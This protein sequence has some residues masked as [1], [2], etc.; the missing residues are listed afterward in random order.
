[1]TRH[2]WPTACPT[3][4]E[5][6]G[7][8]SCSAAA[9]VQARFLCILSIMWWFCAYRK[10]CS[11][12]V[13][14]TQSQAARARQYINTHK[15]HLQ[16]R[17]LLSS[18]FVDC[19]LHTCAVVMGLC[20]ASHRPTLHTSLRRR[21]LQRQPRTLQQRVL[22]VAAVRSTQHKHKHNLKHLYCFC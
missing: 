19:C 18:H 12:C 7:S 14:H 8:G 20:A 3:A 6:D 10:C 17:T 2:R 21:I 22:Q 16:R 13:L 1:M 11:G 15:R 5:S 4:C 9:A